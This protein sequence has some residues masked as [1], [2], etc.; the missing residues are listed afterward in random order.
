MLSLLLLAPL[1]T[2]IL[3]TIGITLWA[4]GKTI[5]L[6]LMLRSQAS[7][8]AAE[9]EQQERQT[10]LQAKLQANRATQATQA[11][12]K[13]KLQ[14]TKLPAQDLQRDAIALGQ[15]GLRALKAGN[16]EAAEQLFAA[17][18][19]MRALHYTSPAYLTA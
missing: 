10:K 16:H 7:V 17:A 18:R 8:A 5:A 2:V 3:T 6:S 9:R 1:A 14:V 12:S 13:I 15:D 19:R 11:A 4:W